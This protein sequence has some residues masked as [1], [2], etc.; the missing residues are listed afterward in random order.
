MELDLPSI[1]TTSVRDERSEAGAPASAGIS[2][3][4]FE[5]MLNSDSRN[6]TDDEHQSHS[7][8]HKPW[9]TLNVARELRLDGSPDDPAVKV[10]EKGIR[11][12][13]QGQLNGLEQAAH[14]LPRNQRMQ[15][16]DDLG[17]QIFD[18]TRNGVVKEH[19]A[20]QAMNKLQRL[21]PEEDS[22]SPQDSN[23]LIGDADALLSSVGRFLNNHASRYSDG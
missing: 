1:P 16:V 20:A 2:G 19:D 10:F 14:T 22:V 5:D 18:A 11:E 8:E 15:T 6:S 23:D 13:L 17:E 21:R 7:Y 12:N 4:R 9:S 3:T